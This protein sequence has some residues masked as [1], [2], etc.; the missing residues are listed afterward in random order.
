MSEQQP[1]PLLTLIIPAYNE[2][3]RLPRSLEKIVAFI[4]QQSEPMD[5]IIVENGS[6]V[7]RPRSPR[8]ERAR[9]IRSSVCCTANR[10]RV[11]W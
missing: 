9:V 7:G 6:R 8:M 11:P 3:R 10:A 2:E 1:E 4:Q 5:V